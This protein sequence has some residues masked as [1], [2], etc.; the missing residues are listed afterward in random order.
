MRSVWILFCLPLC[1]LFADSQEFSEGPVPAWV[2]PCEFPLDPTVK[3]SQINEQILLIDEQTHWEE[4]TTYYH[5]ASKF[6]TQSGAHDFTQIHVEFDPDYERV[7]FHNLR[8]LRDGKWSDRLQSSTYKVI[9][10]EEGLENN[11]YEGVNSLVYFP[12][13]V[14]VGDVIEYSY[15]IVGADP[16][17]SAHYDDEL[18]L[19]QSQA[20]EKIFY[21]TLIDPA[22]GLAMKPFNT[23]LQPQKA[24]LSP[25][26]QEWTWEVL[27]S[28]PCVREDDTPGWFDPRA[29][30]QLSTYK[31]WQDVASVHHPLY[32]LPEDFVPSEEMTSCVSQWKAQAEGDTDRAALAIRFVQNEVKYLGFE[33]GIGGY[34]PTDPRQVFSRRSGDCKDKVLLLQTL[35]KLLD[36]DSLPVLVNADR[37]KNLPEDLPNP[38]FNHVVL[39]IDIGGKSYW[40]EVTMT[41]QTGSLEDNFFPNYYWGLPIS[42][43]TTEL[44]PLPTTLPKHAEEVYTSIVVK[45]PRLAEL[46]ETKVWHDEAAD[47]IRH[48][49]EDIGLSELSK[50]ALERVQKW[51]KGAKEIEPTQVVDD[52]ENNTITAT[53]AY[54]IS[55]RARP[56]KRFLKLVSMIHEYA[57]DTGI[58]PGRSC[59]YRL[60]YPTWVKEHIHVENP[61]ESWGLDV[62]E[63]HHEDAAIKYDYSMKKEGHVADIDF[64]LK[65]LQD[66]VPVETIPEYWDFINEFEPFLELHIAPA[67]LPPQQ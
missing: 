43:E 3:P 65:H 62:E 56:G 55:P 33:Q 53:A 26:L 22:R 28:S 31:T 46:K 60:S 1:A 58:N 17:F 13:D 57:L 49:I 67:G 20:V 7:I 54:E 52:R 11:L 23:S 34:K 48:L 35:L 59:P 10:K 38:G 51:Y 37:G 61:L 4:Q 45:S 12:S 29:R 6:L 8:V 27:E 42:Q 63:M 50:G 40:V 18:Y 24:E 5:R 15:S 64:E 16:V 21:R 66:H 36:I 39:R 30:V 2:K 47:Q 41:H 32:A 25:H 44:I 9:Q 14:R 19:Q